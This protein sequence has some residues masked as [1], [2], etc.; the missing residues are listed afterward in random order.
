MGEMLTDNF[1]TTLDRIQSKNDWSNERLADELEITSRQLQRWRSG[2]ARPHM[3]RA[4]RL[5][6]KFEMSTAEFLGLETA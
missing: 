3:R 5:A 2:E 4:Q 6:E 1:N